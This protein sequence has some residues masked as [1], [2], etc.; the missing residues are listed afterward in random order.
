MTV[1]D[2]RNKVREAL[3]ELSNG[4]PV[5]SIQDEDSLQAMH[6]FDSIL[7][8]EFMVLL[9][10]KFDIQM[11]EDLTLDR[12]DSIHAVTEYIAQRLG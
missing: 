11:D 12:L 8:M 3:T 6:G 10:E 7:L 2:I 5:D 9:E 4:V 1:T